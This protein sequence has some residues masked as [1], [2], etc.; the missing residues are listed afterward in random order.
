MAQYWYIAAA[1]LKVAGGIADANSGAGQI[2]AEADAADQNARILDEKA[3]QVGSEGARNEEA[4]RRQY[5]QLAGEQFAAASE[6]G[7]NATGSVLDIVRQSARDAEV[8]ALNVRYGAQ[9]EARGYRLEAANMRAQSVIARKL[10]K[11]AKLAGY[12]SAGGEGASM[13]GGGAKGGGFNGGK[14]VM[15]LNYTGAGS[16]R[17]A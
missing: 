13:L 1:A 2:R 4:V 17:V 12:L 6:G 8:D 11:R 10:A 7:F 3:L 5:R 16:T 9:T 14:G 15:A